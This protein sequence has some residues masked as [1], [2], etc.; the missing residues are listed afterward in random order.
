MKYLPYRLLTSVTKV[1]RSQHQ[2]YTRHVS[3]INGC[4]AFDLVEDSL[5]CIILTKSFYLVQNLLNKNKML[6][7]F[8]MGGNILLFVQNQQQP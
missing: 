7:H 2:G 4:V 5:Q 1:I 8:E 3:D 6:S